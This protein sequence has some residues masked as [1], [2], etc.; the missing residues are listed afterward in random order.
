MY[1]SHYRL[2]QWIDSITMLVGIPMGFY[3]SL[4]FVP[5]F[6]AFSPLTYAY[7]CLIAFQYHLANFRK[8]A[9]Q[10]DWLRRDL[11]AQLVSAA[12][13]VYF[14]KFGLEGT[15]C[16]A[17]FVYL[18]QQMELAIPSQRYFCYALNGIACLLANGPVLHLWWAWIPNF[19]VFTI[20]LLYPNPWSHGVFHL[21]SHGLIW[22]LWN[23][24]FESNFTN[25]DGVIIRHPY[26]PNNGSIQAPF[27]HH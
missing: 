3:R 4:L 8:N 17:V 5:R 12:T 11:D 20:N 2:K 13:T 15:L 1:P 19:I 24:A 10:L 25:D 23:Q 27:L 16:I 7:M 21:I 18:S 22:Q 26:Q 9:L 14:T 6:E